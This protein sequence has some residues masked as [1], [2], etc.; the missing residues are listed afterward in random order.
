[1]A[2]SGPQCGRDPHGRRGA[3]GLIRARPLALIIDT[4]PLVATLDATDPDHGRCLNLLQESVEPRVVPVC[5]LVEVEYLVRSWPE[6]FPALLADFES[7]AFELL[8]LPPR[9]LQRAGGLVDRYRDLPLGLVDASVIAATE[10]LD[11]PKVATL[12]H[13]HF[14]VVRPMHV[15]ALTLVP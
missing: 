7:G 15:D 4:G 6:A 12:D 2:A 9:W 11:E 13:R 5:V 8:D 10:M 14:T 3:R 1:M